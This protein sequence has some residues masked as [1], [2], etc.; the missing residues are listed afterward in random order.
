MQFRYDFMRA[1]IGPRDGA[2]MA[3]MVSRRRLLPLPLAALLPDTSALAQQRKSLA[4]PLRLG[5]D[6]ALVAS[7]L[8][9]ALLR[10]FGV[11]TG[12]A[13]TMVPGA[14]VPLLQA[15]ERGEIDAALTN[16]PEAELNLEK[17]GLAHDRQP[18]ASGEFV[19]VGPAVRGKGEDV[20]GVALGHD[21]VAALK[22]LAAAPGGLT[23]LTAGDGSGTHL[24]EQA[25]WRQAG[26][27][28]AAPWYVSLAP[29][30]NPMVQARARG[31]FALVERAAWLVRGGAPLAVR[32]EG[33]PRLVEAVHVM[34]A[35]R[36]NHPAGRILV[37]W[38]ASSKGRRIVAAQR[39]YR[40]GA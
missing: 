9:P 32:V 24:A 30:E 5:V 40:G 36:A 2:I 31:A 39:G 37:A 22:R 10:G 29:G 17:Q 28:P 25:L 33:D 26:V 38:F 7:G 19:I 1:F 16:L 3:A 20:L 18:I 21:A 8:A 6:H 34:R 11:D 15:L 23:F 35:F 14:A 4:D 27:A 13:V 12:I